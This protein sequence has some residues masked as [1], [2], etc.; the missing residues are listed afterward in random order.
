VRTREGGG[1]AISVSRRGE[2]FQAEVEVGGAVGA[3]AAAAAGGHREDPKLGQEGAAARWLLEV[4]GGVGLDGPDL[5]RE[6]S[7]TSW[8]LP[9]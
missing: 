7:G 6:G 3:A 2:V 8:R 9:A 1:G 5:G 4:Q